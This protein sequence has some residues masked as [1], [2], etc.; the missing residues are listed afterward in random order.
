MARTTT[1]VRSDTDIPEPIR[2]FLDLAT[3]LIQEAAM[4]AAGEP[5]AAAEANIVRLRVMTSA[6]QTALNNASAQRTQR[7]PG[8]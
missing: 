1:L 2:Q 6:L 8:T 5:D 3:S 4:Y 7:P